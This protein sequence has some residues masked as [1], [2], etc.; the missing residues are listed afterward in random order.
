MINT[1]RATVLSIANKNN[2]GYITP[3][4]FNLYAKQAQLDIFEDYFYQYNSW[5]IKQNARV[6]G[7]EYADILKGLVEVIDSFS[8]TRGLT[9]SGIN[10]YNLPENYYLINKINYYPNAVFSS[11]T[12]A[13]GANTLTDTNATFTTTGTVL[14]GQFVTNTSLTSVSAGFGAYI[15]SVD[16]E[17]QLTLSENPFGSAAT[18]GN[19]YTIVTTAGIR[20]V[21]RVSQNKI[22]YLNSSSLTSPNISYPAYVLGGANNLLTGNTITVYPETII[23][24]GKV[25]SQY[26]RYPLDPNWSYSSLTGG[27]PV[28][29]EGAADYQDFELP[30]SD[31]PNLVNKILQYAGV[32]IRENDIAVFGNIQEQEDNQQQS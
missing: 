26:I 23:G 9:T 27:E 10:L 28:F 3:S 5:I 4:D 6:S 22:F 21:E 24:A 8:E 14:P 11:T 29:D 16:S 30:D 32:S 7:S 31:E 18:V 17:T 1:V 20:E 12:T 15:V 2:Y 25:L 13:A 19:S